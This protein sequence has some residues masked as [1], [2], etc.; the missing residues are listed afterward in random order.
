MTDHDSPQGRA[1]RGDYGLAFFFALFLIIASSSLGYTCCLPRSGRS[2]PELEGDA[3]HHR[4]ER[5]R[6]FLRA[7][8]GAAARS[9]SGTITRSTAS[10]TC[11]TVTGFCAVEIL[12]GRPSAD[13]RSY[14][15]G[16]QC[17]CWVDPRDPRAVLERGVVDGWWVNLGQLPARSSAPPA[18]AGDSRRPAARGASGRGARESAGGAASG[19]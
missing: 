12:G 3:V 8:R 2:A 13:R 6:A 16:R 17:S 1:C 15:A 19:R 11:P 10:A 4:L 9:R 5:G 14:P 7:G 18:C